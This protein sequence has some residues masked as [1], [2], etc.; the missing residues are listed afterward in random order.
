M[1]KL[2]TFIVRRPTEAPLVQAHHERSQLTAVRPEL[3]E[4][5]IQR[6]LDYF[7]FI[8]VRDR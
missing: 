2:I 5:H 3:V 7:W 4:G 8:K 1:K 6:F